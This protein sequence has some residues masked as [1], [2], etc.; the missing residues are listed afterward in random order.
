MKPRKPIDE[1][2]DVEPAPEVILDEVEVTCEGTG[3][4]LEKDYELVRERM[5]TAIVRGSEI[6]D[7]ATKLMK[8][9]PTGMTIKGSADLLKSI[10]DSSKSLLEVHEKIRA[11]QE[12]KANKEEDK[13]EEKT[14]TNVQ[15]ILKL[16][17]TA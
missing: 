15:T 5:I 16:Y 4:D 17:K 12:A 11:M 8:V 9:D 1:M 6:I 3:K 14:K 2:L 13:P 7:E 10:A